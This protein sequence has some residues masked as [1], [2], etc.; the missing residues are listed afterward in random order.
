M[1]TTRKLKLDNDERT[2]LE[3]FNRGEWR[4]VPHLQKEL[5]RHR[6]I[7]RRTLQ[8]MR[9]D[10]RINIRISSG[11]LDSL[12]VRAIEDGIPYQTMISSILH[13]YVSGRLVEKSSR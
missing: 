8:A 9:K 10:R 4:S 2:L 13:R 7:A 1:K 11:D 6:Q 5:R 12:R 3:S